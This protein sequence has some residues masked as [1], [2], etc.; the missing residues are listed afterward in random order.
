[1]DEKKSAWMQL[2]KTEDYWA[3][4]LGLG[5]ILFSLVM[6]ATGRTEGLR[7]IAVKQ[8]SGWTSFST[9]TDHL[10][11]SWGWYIVLFL[12]FLII[13]AISIRIMGY[14]VGQFIP[15]FAVIFLS[16]VLILVLSS[17]AFAKDYNLEAPLLALILGLI[18]GNL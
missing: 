15:G 4:W 12:A 8:P 2:W 17:S 16:S 5:I 9:V 13:F 14:R 7:N 18:V 3:V 1:M 6:Y 11:S 10:A